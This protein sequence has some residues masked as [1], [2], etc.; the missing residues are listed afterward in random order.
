MNGF[1]IVCMHLNFRC[2]VPFVVLVVA[3]L[4]VFGEL[5]FDLVFGLTHAFLPSCIFFKARLK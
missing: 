5:H 4:F 2:L 3:A 1:V